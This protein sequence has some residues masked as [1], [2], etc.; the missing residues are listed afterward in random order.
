MPAVP[1]LADSRAA[2]L[3]LPELRLRRPEYLLRGPGLPPQPSPEHRNY[4][5]TNRA[6]LFPATE[7]GLTAQSPDFSGA[8]V[9]VREVCFSGQPRSTGISG[10][11]S[12]ITVPPRFHPAAPGGVGRA[13]STQTPILWLPR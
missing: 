6:V 9:L 5:R 4:L 12:L 2:S 11:K 7:A 10:G 8:F 13:A 3:H 1:Q